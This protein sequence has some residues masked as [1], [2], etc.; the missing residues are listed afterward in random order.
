MAA[1]A[2]NATVREHQVEAA[3]GAG[4]APGGGGISGREVGGP[5]RA[6][7]PGHEDDPL[8]TGRGPRA[9]QDSQVPPGAEARD[10]RAGPEAGRRQEE[11]GARSEQP[12]RWSQEPAAPGDRLR[13]VLG[14]PGEAAAGPEAEQFPESSELE[15]D[16]AEGLSSRLS[17]TLSF[18][19]AEDE[20]NDN[21]DD[22]E[23]EA[24]PDPLAPGD[25]ASG[26]DA[27]R[28]PPPDGPRGSQLLTRQLQDFWKKSRNTLVPQRLL[29]EV[30]S[31]SVVKD[32]PS[33]Y[34]LYTL[35]VMGP[36]PADRQPAQISRRYSDF[37]QL[38]RSLQRQFRGPMAAISFPR[39]RLRRNF[40]A[41]T[42]ARRS[43]AFEQFLGHLQAVPELRHAQ[44][45]Q[46]FFVLP[47]LRR[48][49]SLTCTGLYREALA[50]WANAWQLQTQLS[51]SSG[52]DRPL[53]TLAGLAV[54]HQELENPGE[55]QACC[56]RALQVL[57]DGNP[58]PLLAP[59]L[60][61]HVRLSWRLGLDK[62]QTEARLQALQE[63]GLTPMPPPSLKELLIKEVLD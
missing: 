1:G 28:S 14:G 4:A 17:G 33:K 47:E 18:T 15:D 30:T 16:D 22:E 55:A 39:K 63:S 9:A 31:A 62:R 61:A 3:S 56:E 59:F 26:E 53:L 24:G 11:A 6:L 54:C 25:A 60:E 46:D 7:G 49:Q 45:L 50:L 57:G 20:D 44:A 36:G 8:E 23:E 42:I 13:H 5:G 27:D 34:V 35:A 51:T 19:S 40:T 32:P 12:G 10:S 41:E 37:E 48:A 38:H 29:F 21:D 2:E 43:R 58:H 52:P